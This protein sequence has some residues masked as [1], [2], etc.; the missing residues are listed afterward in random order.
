MNSEIKKTI[1]CMSVAFVMI[2]ATPVCLHSLLDREIVDVTS[3]IVEEPT[4]TQPPSPTAAIE[5]YPS[6]VRRYTRNRVNLRA[7]PGTDYPQVD[8][9]SANTELEA[10]GKSG[11]WYVIRRDAREVYVA[12]WVTYDTPLPVS[13]D[14][15][16]TGNQQTEKNNCCFIGRQCNTDDEWV[17]GYYNYKN[18]ECDQSSQ[19]TSASSPSTSQSS[20]PSYSCDCSK[21]C[22]YMSSCEEAY[23]QLNECGCSE[24]DGDN[25]S[26]PCEKIC[27]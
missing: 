21:G 14:G 8:S 3:E 23:F 4:P 12:D 26:M 16:G 9:V 11:D 2:L 17:Q 15:R 6:P 27:G 22:D 25:D 1:V 24:R 7:G 5:R 10:I 13:S 18:N 20:Q 19:P